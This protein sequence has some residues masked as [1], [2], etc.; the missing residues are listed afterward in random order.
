[1]EG[2]EAC[3]RYSYYIVRYSIMMYFR[4]ESYM[5]VLLE[6]LAAGYG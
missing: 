6:S 1:M 2:E 5:G 3:G 4:Y